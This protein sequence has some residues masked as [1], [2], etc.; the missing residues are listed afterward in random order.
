MGF[1]AKRIGLYLTFLGAMTVAGCGGRGGSDSASTVAPSTS[2]VAPTTSTTTPGVPGTGT[3]GT[4]PPGPELTSV[5]FDDA[6]GDNTVSR[7]DKVIC[8]FADALEALPAGATP[9][10]EF[11]LQVTGDSF[12]A[13]ATLQLGVDSDEVEIALGDDPK[14]YVSDT[15]AAG[16]TASGAASGINLAATASLKG[17]AADF[18]RPAAEALDIDGTLKP[19][20]HATSSLNEAR[21]SHCSV[22]LDD[23][24]I[25]IVGGIAGGTQGDLV[26]E[27]ELF[28]PL[29]GSFTRVSDLSGDKG[30]MK[31]GKVKVRTFMATATKLKDGTVLI[32][33]GQGVERRGFFGLGKE[34]LDTLESAFIFSPLDNS[35]S[36]VG[37]MKYPR[38]SHTAT[39]LD[40]GTVLIAGG[41]NDSFWK[42]HKTQAPVELYDPMKKEF[43]KLGSFFK[44]F[45]MKDPRMNHTATALAGGQAVLFTGGAHYTGGG[46]FGLIKPKLRMNTGA[47]LANTKQNERTGDLNAPRLDHAAVALPGDEVFIAGGRDLTTGAVSPC[48]VFDPAANAWT[49]AGSLQTPRAHAQIA[50][51]RSSAL[52]IG[53]HAGYGET[54]WVEVFD[55]DAKQMS[56]TR[57]RL[58]N[59]RNGHTVEKLADGRILVIGGFTG[60]VKDWRSID[61]Q[62][63]SSC[64]MFVSH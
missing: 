38:H 32:C 39:L 24:R 6:D 10:T 56:S 37:D 28:D 20:F 35:F 17:D 29:T 46:L 62:A 60:G 57:Y 51:D 14:L 42:S 64:E 58:N 33:G 9:T 63:L 21:G 40:D 16:N 27:A 55:A 34:K 44:R 54:G 61:G 47:E 12:G 25:L 1:S 26:V 52:I 59:L 50:F 41:Y 23:G 19:T 45:K 13:G 18:A 49:T 22:T 7:G 5:R 31:R 30:Y 3:P 36:R 4:L 43:K 53:G 48:E 15:F 8:T 2:G 11:E